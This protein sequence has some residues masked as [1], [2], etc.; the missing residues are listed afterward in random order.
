MY[1]FDNK[2]SDVVLPKQGSS[3]YIKVSVNLFR[4]KTLKFKTNSKSCI[5]KRCCDAVSAA[6]PGFAGSKHKRSSNMVLQPISTSLFP[7]KEM[8]WN[9]DGGILF[10]NISF[11]KTKTIIFHES[12]LTLSEN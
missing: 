9:G 11:P 8:N 4:T 2:K 10:D 3:L 12:L 5:K 6:L 1:D 7:R